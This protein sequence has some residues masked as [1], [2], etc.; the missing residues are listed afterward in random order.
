MQEMAMSEKEEE[1]T[2]TPTPPAYR[3]LALVELVPGHVAL[4]LCWTGDVWF[5]LKELMRLEQA[6]QFFYRVL[7]DDVSWVKDVVQGRP[8][9]VKVAATQFRGQTTMILPERE[10]GWPE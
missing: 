2:P 1:T 3:D 7:T 8:R 9:T 4:C 10:G 6:N 5:V